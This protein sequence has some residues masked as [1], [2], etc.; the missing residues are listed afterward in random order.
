M[1]ALHF[2]PIRIF[3]WPSV[4]MPSLKHFASV[5]GN[6][7]HEAFTSTGSKSSYFFMGYNGSIRTG[8][9]KAAYSIARCGLVGRLPMP[10]WL[11]LVSLVVVA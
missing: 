6:A 7:Q 11:L 3:E 5:L 9:Q 10:T 8:C 1:S 4:P 2:L